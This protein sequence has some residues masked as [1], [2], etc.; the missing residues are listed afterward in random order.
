MHKLERDLREK[1]WFLDFRD[2]L[3]AKNI[4][5][6]GGGKA[7][8]KTLNDI[9]RHQMT[10]K[11]G[12]NEWVEICS[13]GFSISNTRILKKAKKHLED[14]G[15]IQIKNNP[16]NG[17][18]GSRCCSY[19]LDD[20]LY[21]NEL[22]KI[23]KK[24]AVYLKRRV[25]KKKAHNILN[26]EL[27]AII[28]ANSEKLTVDYE[29]L[30]ELLI[31]SENTE[32]LIQVQTVFDKFI[33]EDIHEITKDRT[34]RIH[35]P[36]LQVP[37]RFR[38]FVYNSDG[39]KLVDLDMVA[40]HPAILLHLYE[41]FDYAS[42]IAENKAL[43]EKW[44]GHHRSRDIQQGG[45]GEAPSYSL[46]PEEKEKRKYKKAVKNDI[47]EHLGRK[48]TE[49][50]FKNVFYSRPQVKQMFSAFLNSSSWLEKDP[51]NHLKFRIGRNKVN[52]VGQAFMNEFPLLTT[53]MQMEA[54]NPAFDIKS[55]DGDDCYGIAIMR[56]ESKIMRRVYELLAKK[57]LFFIPCHDGVLVE[58]AAV[59]LTRRTILNSMNRELG[60]RY[61]ESFIKTTYL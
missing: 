17:P 5:W 23:R 50:S 11:D 46:P 27:H 7:A 21:K 60:L 43:K 12:N 34:D 48:V 56:M 13:G 53:I 4:P 6:I 40:A 28:Q 44:N 3:V 26:N 39:K 20:D 59:A 41:K 16:L 14:A 8:N 36:W 47:Y 52:L 22:P 37:K 51:V 15:L 18:C 33:K 42:F 10:W 29:R 32:D 55:K 54:K 57:S 30:Y 25:T 1:E 2:Q 61:D 58:E 35:S 45:S 24:D 31:A 9:R 49:L 19:K 38:Q